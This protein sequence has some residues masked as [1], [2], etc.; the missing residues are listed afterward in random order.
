MF[1]DHFLNKK[2]FHLRGHLQPIFQPPIFSFKFGAKIF[3]SFLDAVFHALSACKLLE[4]RMGAESY[5]SLRNPNRKKNEKLR[6]RNK[7]VI[8]YF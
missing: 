5:G 3:I 6:C 1:P 2:L 4:I 7:I 8:F